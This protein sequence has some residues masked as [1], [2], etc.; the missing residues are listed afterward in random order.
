MKLATWNVFS[1]DS[2]TRSAKLASYADVDIIA[3]QETS[4]SDNTPNCVWR[5]DPGKTIKGVSIWSKYE[6]EITPPKTPCSIGLGAT[7]NHPSLGLLNILNLWAKPNPDYFD[8]LML[9]LKAYDSFIQERPTI[10]MGDFNISP[11]LAGKKRKFANLVQ[12]FED[13]LGLKSAYHEFFKLGYGEE[14]HPTLYFRWQESSPFHIDYVFMPPSLISRL[15]SVDIPSFEHFTSSD[16][17]P[18]I[19]ELA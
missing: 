8:D 16:H 10:I 19:C 3:F 15:V 2:Q 11:K 9:S 7:I 13:E 6:L 17:R 18:V 5:G 1:G 12:Y 4:Y 14:K